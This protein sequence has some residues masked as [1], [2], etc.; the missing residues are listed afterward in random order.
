[1]VSAVRCVAMSA[2]A[3][4]SLASIACAA[5]P[6][7]ASCKDMLGTA[8]VPPNRH[9]SLTSED[10]I[11]LTDIGDPATF[12]GSPGLSLS[13]DGRL[14]AF[15]VR[16]AVLE[17]NGYCTGIAVLD[18]TKRG[19]PLLLDMGHELALQA[20]NVQGTAQPGAYP[21]LIRPKWSPSG[22]WLAFF[23]QTGGTLQLWRAAPDGSMAVP[24]VANAGDLEEFTWLSDQELRVS[25][26][27]GRTEAEHA[28]ATEEASGYWYDARFLPLVSDRPFPAAVSGHDVQIIPVTSGQR[29]ETATPD[30]APS[31]PIGPAGAVRFARSTQ[32]DL[33]WTSRLEPARYAGATTLTVQFAGGKPMACAAAVCG[34]IESLGW[35]KAQ[36]LVFVRRQGW[37]GSRTGVYVW[38]RTAKAPTALLLTDDL[39]LDCQAGQTAVICAHEDARHPRS[40]VSIALKDGAL[41]TLF[42][43]NP[44]Y[45]RLPV[46]RIERLYWRNANGLE[47]YG[48]LVFPSGFKAG[49][50]YPTIVTTYQS[51]GFLRGATGDEYPIPLFAARGY[52]VLSF[53]RP[54]DVGI[55]VAGVADHLAAQRVAAHDW[56]DR[57]SVQSSIETGLRLLDRRGML[58]RARVGITGLSDGATT[59]QFALLNSRM[60][61]AAS[62]SSCCAEPDSLLAAVGPG[63]SALFRSIGYPGDPMAP[64]WKPMSFVRNAQV[65]RTPLL[66]QLAS[67]EF[68]AALSSFSELQAHRQPTALYVFSDEGHVKLHPVHRLAIYQ[69]NLAWF[70]FWLKGQRDDSLVRPGD[71]ERWDALRS[72]ALQRAQSG[73]D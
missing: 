50:R 36:D 24:I 15:A 8:S 33:A 64:F 14:L 37:A 32:G 25:R 22:H 53:A 71:L 23:K 18:L 31:E 65:M 66:M 57:R 13:P 34:G 11:E 12:A 44:W 2:C 7:D 46:P 67:S 21:L 51:R 1:M 27:S 63:T 54:V 69:R 52:A 5:H 49:T 41:R 35:T 61:A 4:W 17:T 45:G 20:S 19:V 68:R 56:A 60:F 30:H 70:D 55:D 48:D 16:K 72:S 9:G 26:R 40:I 29:R 39:L 42:D 38:H 3:Y 43:P 73:S 10:L 28:I 59:V 58:D 47:T 6:T 62:L